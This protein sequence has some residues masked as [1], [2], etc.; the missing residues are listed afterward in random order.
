VAPCDV[1]GASPLKEAKAD[2][3]ALSFS[4][5]LVSGRGA[6][7]HLFLRR[8]LFVCGDE[9][10]AVEGDVDDREGNTVAVDELTLP[11]T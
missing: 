1:G 6:S 8:F 10:N 5:R 9:A 4:L 2:A 11:T 7:D 3:I